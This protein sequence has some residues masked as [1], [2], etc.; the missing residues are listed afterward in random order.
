MIWAARRRTHTRK[1]A[2]QRATRIPVFQGSR[3]LRELDP[4][5]ERRGGAGPE[6]T[7]VASD[8]RWET[9][10]IGSGQ[11]D[12][13]SIVNG[14]G[15]EVPTPTRRSVCRRGFVGYAAEPRGP[16]RGWASV[17]D[18]C[19]QARQLRTSD[20]NRS[21]LRAPPVRT[22]GRFTR[23]AAEASVES[24]SGL[25]GAGRWIRTCRCSRQRAFPEKRPLR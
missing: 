22:G 19:V 16:P 14:D 10:G 12:I 5:A 13:V 1:C 8:S 6:G 11:T 20:E 18:S 21:S 15:T 7:A 24:R 9:Q 25:A 2:S 23:T 17:P 4:K 3:A